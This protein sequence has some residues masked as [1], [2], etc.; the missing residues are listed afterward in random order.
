V[1]GMYENRYFRFISDQGN[2]S[3][4]YNWKTNLIYGGIG[5][6]F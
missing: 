4:L 2:P 3:N 6:A 1:K 5:V